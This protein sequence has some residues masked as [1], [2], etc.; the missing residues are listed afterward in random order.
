MRPSGGVLRSLIPGEAG[1]LL[2]HRVL[3]ATTT[4]WERRAERETL[5]LLHRLYH[6]TLM[7]QGR[8]APHHAK[9]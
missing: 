6:H 2:T 1:R 8:A 9:N 5:C 3:I 4:R 7:R